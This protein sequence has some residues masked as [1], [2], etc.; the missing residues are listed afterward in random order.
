MKRRSLTMNKL[1]KVTLDLYYVVRAGDDEMIQHAKDCL[2][3][4]IM[5]AVKHDELF[6][7]IRV[8][9]APPNTKE[10]DIPEFLLEEVE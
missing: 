4:D 9:D 3:E 8:V 2:Y 7:L 1:K 10:C 5:S 6:G